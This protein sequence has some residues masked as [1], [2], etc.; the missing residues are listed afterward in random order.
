[1]PPSDWRW[2][3]L[4]GRPTNAAAGS[5]R[6]PRTSLAMPYLGAH[7][8]GTDAGRALAHRSS[9]RR[10]TSTSSGVPRLPEVGWAVRQH[11]SAGP[12]SARP[13]GRSGSLTDPVTPSEG[14]YRTLGLCRN[15]EL[16]SGCSQAER[17][18]RGKS[19]A[20]RQR[21]RTAC[22]PRVRSGRWTLNPSALRLK[23]LFSARGPPAEPGDGS[24]TTDSGKT[25]VGTEVPPTASGSRAA[26][27]RPDRRS[28]RA[29]CGRHRC[30]A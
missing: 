24:S 29:S 23:L 11:P 22:R 18:C 26:G 12:P 13:L 2:R 21:L 28:N 4:L 7:P 20:P 27:R 25:Y 10:S 15:R 17:V 14:C 16:A 8:Q 5:H 1:M 6:E 19:T 3:R 9:C 30:C